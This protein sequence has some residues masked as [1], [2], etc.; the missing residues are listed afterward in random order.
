MHPGGMVKVGSRLK[1]TL[2]ISATGLHNDIRLL[3]K[4]IPKGDVWRSE[5]AV[6]RGAHLQ[7]AGLAPQRPKKFRVVTKLPVGD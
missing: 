7:L 5:G 4:Q 3:R 6:R 1:G 2:R